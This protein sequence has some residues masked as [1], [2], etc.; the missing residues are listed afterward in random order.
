MQALIL[1]AYTLCASYGQ[2]LKEAMRP[3]LDI[4]AYTPIW[5]STACLLLLTRPRR[6]RGD[7]REINDVRPMQLPGGPPSRAACDP[8]LRP[9]A[10]TGGAAHFAILD[11]GQPAGVRAA[12][13][14]CSRRGVW[15]WTGQRLGRNILP[16]ERDGLVEIAPGSSDRRTKGTTP[17]QGRC[18]A[19]S[20]CRSGMGRGSGT[21]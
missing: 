6:C 9:V 7:P 17:D 15:R 14:Q 21:V 19:A 3:P 8:V 11:F 5:M 1:G 13:N 18:R 4:G 12:I 2:S 20:R 10:C 16:L